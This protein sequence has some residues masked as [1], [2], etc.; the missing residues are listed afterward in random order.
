MYLIMYTYIHIHA[1][2][3]ARSRMHAHTHTHTGVVLSSLNAAGLFSCKF[4]ATCDH[5]MS[6]AHLSLE[7][8]LY[9]F[10]YIYQI[11]VNHIYKYLE[12]MFILRVYVYMQSRNFIGVS[13][14]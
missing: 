7:P 3:H 10:V 8:T 13:L 14:S 5:G 6:L 12:F 1:F 2:I 4:C 11:Y 9:M